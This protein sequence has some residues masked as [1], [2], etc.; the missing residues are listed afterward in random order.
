MKPLRFTALTTLVHA[1]IVSVGFTFIA[2]PH[3]EDIFES[4]ALTFLALVLVYGI[5]DYIVVF[6]LTLLC[7]H[8][9]YR[10]TSVQM[11]KWSSPLAFIVLGILIAIVGGLAVDRAET[12]Y[13]FIG[14]GML[15]IVMA[16]LLAGILFIFRLEPFQKEIVDDELLNIGNDL[17][18]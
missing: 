16:L 14:F 18:I 3:A 6:F 1:I 17:N 9:T 5:F 12:M 7:I 10:R 11:I 15:T 8:L 2:L 4:K 13:M